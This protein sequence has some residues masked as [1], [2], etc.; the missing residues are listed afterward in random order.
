MVGVPTGEPEAVVVGDTWR[1]RRG[2]LVS[3]YPAGDGWT[4]TYVLLNEAGKI[5]IA[6]SA[7]GDGFLVDEAAAATAAHAAGRYRWEASVSKDEDRFRVGTGT[8]EVRPDFAAAESLDTRSHAR[9]VLE[10]IEAV[11]ERRAT[12]DQEEYT[13][14]GRSLKRTP[15]PELT[16]LRDRYRAE[17]RREEQSER[18]AQGRGSGRIMLTRFGA[19]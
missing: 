18:A 11:I 1:W 14:D 17:V 19:R 5:T 13:I 12:K 15:I 4:L 9:K 6:A 8:I 16:A 2:D 7:D 10:K 3:L